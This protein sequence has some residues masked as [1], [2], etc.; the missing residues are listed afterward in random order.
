MKSESK[1]SYKCKF[2]D[3]TYAKESTLFAHLCEQKRRHNQQNETGVQ[4]GLRAYLKFYE[5]T[6]GSTKSKNYEEF[7]KSP[8]YVAF[9]KFGRYCVGIRCINFI[10]FTEWLLQNNKKLDYW[11]SD[12]LYEEWMHPYLRKEAPQDSLERALKEMQEYADSH[13]ELQNGFVDYF[14]HGNVN[15]IIHHICTGR[16]SPWILFNC[17]SGIEF[18]GGLSED[19]TAIIWKYIEP[20]YWQRKFNDY[21]ADAEWVKGILR[22][23]GL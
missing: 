3:K 11:C 22:Q 18:L 17:D 23:A 6:Q 14:R 12:R 15:R 20:D 8:Y 9:V 13:P 19:Q 7:S 1:P 4:F 5:M 21:V 16:I 2:C 10:N